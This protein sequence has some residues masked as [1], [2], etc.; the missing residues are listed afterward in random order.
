[1]KKISLTLVLLGLFLFSVIGQLIEGHHTYNEERQQEFNKPKVT[2]S[3]YMKSGHF[4]SSLS[5]NMESEFLQLALFVIL[6]VNLYQIASSESNKL[7][8]QKTAHD[9]KEELDEKKYSATQAQKHPFLWR[10][11][12]VS[13]TL[14]MFILFVGFF[15]LHAYGSWMMV[16][17]QN[18]VLQ[19]PVL[20]FWEIFKESEF[21]FES[22]QNW[23]SEF[24]SVVTL[25][26]CSIFLRQK[27][28]PQSKKMHRGLWYT[29]SH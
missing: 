11:Y 2:M 10:L 1:M 18:I 8:Q 25:G 3:Q 20:E 27:G 26:L 29:G 19:K 21:W 16:N 24:F 23:Q 28:S 4:I 14:A 12:E 5:E 15:F 17:E 7:P 13:L 9:L 22:F 6:T